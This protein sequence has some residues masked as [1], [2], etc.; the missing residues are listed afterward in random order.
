MFSNDG[1]IEGD[2]LRDS[3]DRLLG[4]VKQQ[5]ELA[6]GIQAVFWAVCS[7]PPTEDEA[8]AI[9]EYIEKRPEDERPAT[10][11]QA[12]WALLTGPEIRFNY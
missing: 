10:L 12:V 9:R 8:T 2:L 11:K 7:R 6:D 1:G 4:F 3:G 5:E